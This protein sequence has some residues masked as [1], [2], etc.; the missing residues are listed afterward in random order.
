MTPTQ[1]TPP[2][3]GT[4]TTNKRGPYA[5]SRRRREEIATAVLELVDEVG[6]EGVTTALVASRSG[7]PEATVLYHFPSKDQLLIA[8]LRRADDLAATGIDPDAEDFGLD[9]E[10]L[11]RH[12][13]AAMDA[14]PRR[15]RLTEM[16]RGQA[17]TEGHPAAEYFRELHERAVTVH[18][19][20]IS[21]RQRAGLAHPGLDPRTVARQVIALWGGLG[22]MRIVDPAL[23]IGPLL[24]DGIR[25]LSGENVMQIR[26]LLD[27]PG[28]G[29]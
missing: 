19:R 7:T 12:V 18:A 1:Q 27:D 22:A 21:N 9:L 25:R 20:I 8:A 17:A 2:P 16:M 11:S 15:Q 4:Q 6:H 28:V 13:D 26:A 5:R 10:E 3:A 24:G 23:R 29:L 14:Q